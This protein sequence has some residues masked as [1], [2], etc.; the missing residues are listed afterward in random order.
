MMRTGGR[1]VPGAGSLGGVALL[2]AV[3]LS[4]VSFAGAEEPSTVALLPFEN[5]SGR[6]QSVRVI[7]PAVARALQDRGYRLVD[8]AR[9]E[10]FL[11]RNRIRDTGQLSRTQAA[12]LG[13]EFGVGVAMVGSVA[14]FNDSAEN[15]QWG[16]SARFLATESGAIVWA[17]SVGLTGDDFTIALG[18]GTVTSSAR[19][20]EETA[21]DLLRDLPRAGEPL[22]MPTGGRG[23]LPRLFSPKASYRSP[24]L[25]SD[26]PKRVAVLLFEN[27]SERKGAGRI[28]TDVFVT[29]LARSGR[30]DVVEPGT[31]TEALVAAG[32]APYG[33][34][35]FETLAA[36]RQR[37]EADAVILGTVFNYSEGLKRTAT[38]SP[39]VAFDAR[40]LDAETGRVLWVAERVRNGDDSQIALHFG[41]IRAVVPLVLRVADEM[42]ET[43]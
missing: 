42:V 27:L 4:A 40:M 36:V 10:A 19:L 33:D 29:A 43:L 18:L 21:T 5:V 8:P 23:L 12:A 3:V 9:L 16:L 34:I 26:P 7:M 17:G 28:V 38:T 39:E 31:V 15:P 41:K 32:A 14:I 2:A 1:G 37:L 13:R 11:A 30:F 35:D 20:A 6:V 24:A 25:T 22:R